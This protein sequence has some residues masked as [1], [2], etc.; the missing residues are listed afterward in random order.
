MTWVVTIS[1]VV[2][3]DAIAE[4]VQSLEAPQLHVQTCTNKCVRT[5]LCYWVRITVWPCLLYIPVLISFTEV[6]H[7]TQ[8]ITDEVILNAHYFY[9]TL[10]SS[11]LV[12][13]TLTMYSANML[14]L[15]LSYSYPPIAVTRY[16]FVFP[17]SSVIFKKT[18][19]IWRVYVRRVRKYASQNSDGVLTHAP[20]YSFTIVSCV[21]KPNLSVTR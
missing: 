15:V 21:L 20:D 5:K 9:H 3:P 18:L 11:F 6:E 4:V 16:L 10:V 7:I 17:Y 14:H 8:P 1:I 13:C 19:L 2:P 12:V